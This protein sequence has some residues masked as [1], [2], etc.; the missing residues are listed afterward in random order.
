MIWA[1]ATGCA[2]WNV[3]R[4]FESDEALIRGQIDRL[5]S[6]HNLILTEYYIGH[7]KWAE[8]QVDAGY[9]IQHL[10]RLRNVALLAFGRGMERLPECP[11][12]LSRAITCA[13]PCPGQMRG[14]RAIFSYRGDRPS[15]PHANALPQIVSTRRRKTNTTTRKCGKVGKKLPGGLCGLPGAIEKAR[16]VID[17]AGFFGFRDLLFARRIRRHIAL[18]DDLRFVRITAFLFGVL[19]D[20]VHQADRKT[21]FVERPIVTGEVNDVHAGRFGDG[22]V[23]SAV[24]IVLIRDPVPVTNVSVLLLGASIASRAC[25]SVNPSN[26]S[27]EP[28]AKAATSRQGAKN[29]ASFVEMPPSGQLSP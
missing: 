12:L 9:S 26:K 21:V 24:L 6:V 13:R 18:E 3:S 11:A 8:V 4:L 27:R 14:L 16:Q 17:P 25:S 29:S 7:K 10:K 1:L 2:V 28:S 15:G 5:D 19:G 23:V 22:F 20:F